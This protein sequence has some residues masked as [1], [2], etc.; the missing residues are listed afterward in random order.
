M[1]GFAFARAQMTLS[2]VFHMVFAAIGIGLPLMMVVSEAIYLRT[3]RDHYKALAKKWAKGAGLLFAIGAV[4]GTALSLELGLLWPKYMEVIGA[5]V[6]HIFG[7][8]GFAFFIEAIFL[9]LYLYGWDKLSK[10]A[11]LACGVVVAF[12][13][14]LSGVLVLGVNAWMHIPVGVTFNPDGSLLVNDPV[15]IFRNPAWANMAIHSTLSCYQATAFAVAAIYAASWLRGRRDDY[16]A[17]GLKLAMA[18]GAVV[19]IAQPVSGD[20]L[21]RFVF[22]TQPVKFA[23]MEGQYETQ[24]R[25]P[26]RIGGWPDDEAGQT[27]WAI[28]IP[29]GLSFLANGDFNT[30]IVGLNAVPRELRPNVHIVHL[31]FQIM[32]GLGTAMALLGVWFWV[33]W[34]RKRRAALDSRWLLRAILIS[35]SFGFIALEAGWVVTE[36]G[37]MPWVIQGVMFAKDAV[38]SSSDVPAMFALFAVLYGLLGWTTIA[39]LRRLARG[40]TQEPTAPQ[41]VPLPANV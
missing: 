34:W 23:A 14:A 2:L 32:V 37:R 10:K 27:R 12:A 36:A 40:G 6:G 28:E 8:E 3:G 15:A 35:G 18:V 13:G 19:A 29:G 38:T 16:V 21:A 17:G 5:T 30:E 41:E 39:L 33:A 24:R 22:Q 11:H 20:I 9:A 7:L 26:L 31:A 4:S 25:A 1:D